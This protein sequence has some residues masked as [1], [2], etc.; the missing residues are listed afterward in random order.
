M[1][2]VQVGFLALLLG[3]WFVAT[4][5]A[6][7]HRLLLPDLSSVWREMQALAASGE[8]WRGARVTLLTVAEA[9]AIAVGLGLLVGFS[10]SR[11][12]H[13]VRLLEPILSGFFAIPLT[14]FFPLFILFFGIG[15][16][17]KLAYGAL[18]ALLPIALASIAAFSRVD[19]LLIGSARSM[20]ASSAKLL[21]RVYLPAAF[22]GVLN[23]MRI[24][25]VICIAA[26]LGG[27]T[28]AS[29]SGIGFA[30]KT[31]AELMNVARMYAWLVFVVIASFALNLLL[32]VAERWSVER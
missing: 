16:S 14:L 5:A 31:S 2:A 26:V 25:L 19:P 10:V 22:P 9:Y 4:N 21:R 20:G 28:I 32:S 1:R 13:A 12:R 29:S 11:S 8:L 18:Y 17:S 15:T 27:E 30:I 7:V 6:H 3:L 23:G 24:A